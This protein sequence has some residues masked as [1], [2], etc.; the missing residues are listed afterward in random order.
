MIEY[1]VKDSMFHMAAASEKD[2]FILYYG[3]GSLEG[4]IRNIE[5]SAECYLKGFIE[6]LYEK[7]IGDISI[8]LT[9][10]E[11]KIPHSLAD[12]Y[13]NYIFLNS[14]KFDARSIEL[15]KRTENKQIR[16][17]LGDKFTREHKEIKDNL[18]YMFNCYKIARFPVDNRYA[19]EN[20]RGRSVDE[21]SL[22]IMLENFK[23]LKEFINNHINRDVIDFD[24]DKRVK[25]AMEYMEL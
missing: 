16:A 1:D 6:N 19:D 13:G 18:Q 10:S 4:V 3:N 21:E 17:L 12:L 24:I 14:S 15:L 7:S 5:H 9:G 20:V 8:I 2:A 23:G 11:R 22:E 25:N